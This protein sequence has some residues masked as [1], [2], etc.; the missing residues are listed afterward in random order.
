MNTCTDCGDRAAEYFDPRDDAMPGP[1]LCTACLKEA[2]A[3]RVGEL[4]FEIKVL[5]ETLREATE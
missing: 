1:C 4:E 5:K 2:T 3:E